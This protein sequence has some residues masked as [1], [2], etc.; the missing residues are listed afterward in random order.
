MTARTFQGFIQAV[1]TGQA[2]AR[3]M[4]GF[5]QVVASIQPPFAEARGFQAFVQVIARTYKVTKPL[6]PEPENITPGVHNRYALLTM[7]TMKD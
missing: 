7:G 1:G 5:V 4:Q 3:T 6:Y 2:N